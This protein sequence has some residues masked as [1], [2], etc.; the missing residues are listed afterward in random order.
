[1]N[2]DIDSVVRLAFFVGFIGVVLAYCIGPVVPYLV[3]R[4]RAKW[5]RRQL[6]QV[7]DEARARV[8]RTEGPRV[9]P[10]LQPGSDRAAVS[11]VR[12][13]HGRMAGLK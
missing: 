6:R 9:S 1:M 7:V 13:F 3:D 10:D 12:P 5:R 11:R 8:V 4:L 2:E